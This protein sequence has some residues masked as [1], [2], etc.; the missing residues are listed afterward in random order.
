V[1]APVLEAGMRVPLHAFFL[2]VLAHK[3]PLSR[4]VSHF[5]RLDWTLA[6]KGF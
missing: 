4:N 5:A 2:E 6:P 1:Y 3:R